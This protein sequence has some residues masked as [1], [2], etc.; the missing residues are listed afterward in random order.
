MKNA[1]I[2][3]IYRILSK[4]FYIYNLRKVVLNTT[5]EQPLRFQSNQSNQSSKIESIDYTSPF[6]TS[7]SFLNETF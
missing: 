6:F 3:C 2:T 1:F 5:V 4:I 7:P